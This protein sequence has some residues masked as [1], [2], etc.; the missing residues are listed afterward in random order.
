MTT[1]L[2]LKALIS[3]F[4]RGELEQR[5]SKAFSGRTPTQRCVGWTCKRSWKHSAANQGRFFYLVLLAC[6]TVI[7][8]KIL[9]ASIS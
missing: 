3:P 7:A 8:F 9:K 2:N 4:E 6:N 5:K 1:Q